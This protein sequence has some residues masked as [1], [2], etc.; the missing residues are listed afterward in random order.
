MIDE[1]RIQLRLFHDLNSRGH[2]VILPNISHSWLP[3]EAD[4]ISVTKSNY[5]NEYEIKISLQDFKKDFEKRKHQY[6]KR[7]LGHARNYGTPNY[8]WYV[9]PPKAVPI[10]IPDY[11]GLIVLEP[12]NRYGMSYYL[13]RV[14][15]AKRLHTN[16]LS[17]HGKFKMLRTL[18]YKYWDMAQA[19]DNSKVQRKLF[20]L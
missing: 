20:K 4:L 8:F 2:T 7:D 6:F 18:M 10:C 9:A 1:T 5:M 19:L 17:E 12:C 15:N 11:A 14:R 3:W 16:K 13:S